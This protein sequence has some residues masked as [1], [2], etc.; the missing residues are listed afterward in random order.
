MTTTWV[1]NVCVV[2]SSS[3]Y[4]CA[5]SA[6][7]A[8]PFQ[9]PEGDMNGLRKGDPSGLK[10]LGVGPRPD[11]QEH[12][13]LSKRSD[14]HRGRRLLQTM[15]H[16]LQRLHDALPRRVEGGIVRDGDLELETALRKA[17]LIRELRLDEHF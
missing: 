16:V 13:R 1:L 8:A 14:E 5:G 9:V 7:E 10:I 6:P 2:K 17:R 4:F 11:R 12:A 3:G 15:R